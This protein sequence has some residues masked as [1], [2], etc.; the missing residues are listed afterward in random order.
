[1]SKPALNRVREILNAILQ[2]GS[3]RQDLILELERFTNGLEERDG[4]PESLLMELADL[5]LDLDDYEPNP[6]YRSEDRAYYGDE[7]LVE[8]VTGFLKRMS[9]E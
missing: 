1:M 9:G 2:E 6:V 3:D 5:V 4:V 7:K 8:L